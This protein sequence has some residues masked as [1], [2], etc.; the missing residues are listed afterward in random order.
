[1]KTSGPKKKF[2]STIEQPPSRPSSARD[3]K[4][5]QD[6]PVGHA[7][8]LSLSR[9]HSDERSDSF[10]SSY[11]SEGAGGRGAEQMRAAAQRRRSPKPR[12]RRIGMQRYPAD[13]E[14]VGGGGQ[15][16]MSPEEVVSPGQRQRAEIGSTPS[17]YTIFQNILQVSPKSLLQEY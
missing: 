8:H 17:L 16:V 13:F 15:D 11:S 2:A 5:S 9:R 7:H 6:S 3:K 10:H 1:M 4:Y 14:V 12:P